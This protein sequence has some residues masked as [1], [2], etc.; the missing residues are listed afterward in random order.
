MATTEKPAEAIV[1]TIAHLAQAL[2]MDV[3]AEGVEMPQQVEFLREIGCEYGQGYLF[4]KPLPADEAF[5]LLESSSLPI[6]LR[7]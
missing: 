3:V 5:E 1:K 2:S 7:R 4:A 6:N